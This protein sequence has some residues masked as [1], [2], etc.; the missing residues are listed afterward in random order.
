[1]RIEA[2][3]LTSGEWQVLLDNCDLL[4]LLPRLHANSYSYG[5]NLCMSNPQGI[6]KDEVFLLNTISLLSLSPHL[7][8]TVESHSGDHKIYL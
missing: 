2:T 4:L 3:R 7:F 8:T 1:M 5:H 6:A